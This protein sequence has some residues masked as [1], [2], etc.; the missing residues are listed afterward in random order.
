MKIDLTKVSSKGQVVIPQEIRSRMGLSDG[1]VLI[2]SAQDDIIV[3]K[4]IENPIEEEDM[5][6]LM[7]IK[8]A[9]KEIQSGQCKRMKEDEFLKEISQ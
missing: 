1:E 6:T 4:K 9:W 2:V 7:E 5:K 8:D 3:L